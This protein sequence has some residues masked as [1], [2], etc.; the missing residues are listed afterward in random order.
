MARLLSEFFTSK[1]NI[2]IPEFTTAHFEHTFHLEGLIAHD[3]KDPVVPFVEGKKLA[4]AWTKATFI[5]T[6]NLGHSMHN[7]ALYDQITAFT[8]A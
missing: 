3:S 6:K 8:T 4:N 5:A 2:H 1:Y 7:E